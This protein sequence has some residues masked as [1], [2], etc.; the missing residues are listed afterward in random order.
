MGQEPEPDDR[1]RAREV[2]VERDRAP[3][4]FVPAG[5]AADDRWVD[6]GFAADARVRAGS[7]ERLD[8][9]VPR[10]AVSPLLAAAGRDAVAEPDAR[11]EAAVRRAAGL[12]A[13]G[14]RVAGLRAAGL[15]AAGLPA[16]VVRAAGLLAPGRSSA[17]TRRASASISP[18]RPLTSS[19][20]LQVLDRLADPRG[21]LRDLVDDLPRALLS[22]AAPLGRGLEG[23]LDG[24]ADGLHGVRGA[25]ALLVL[26][27]LVL[28]G[29]GASLFSTRLLGPVHLRPHAEVAERVLLP[30]DPGRAL[31]LAQQLLDAPKMLNHNRGLWGYTG[32]AAD[33]EPLTIQSTGLG[34]AERGD[35]R[36]GADRAR[37][38]PARAGRDVRR[39]DRPRAG[40]ARDRRDRR[41]AR[42]QPAARS[43]PPARSP[44]TRRCSPRCAPPATA[45][46]PASSV[47]DLYYGA[48][49]TAGG[50]RGRAT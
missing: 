26:L 19:S 7:F 17:A 13:A 12:R 10:A 11:D 50:R 45:R 48:D 38:A 24:V 27:L 9:L 23:A 20:T 28:L 3:V 37:R 33:G 16:A 29:H 4:D 42:R 44:P 47:G 39:A 40:L 31:R 46:R 1:G 18:R 49:T 36:R 8:A 15:R 30:G 21:R 34:R 22:V 43:A 2:P 14:L 35:R 32:A 6:A 41:C 5:F 25:G